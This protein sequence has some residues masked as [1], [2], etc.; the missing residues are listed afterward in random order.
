MPVAEAFECSGMAVRQSPTLFRSGELCA[1][2]FVEFKNI[3]Y[4]I[5]A[6][7]RQTV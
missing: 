5:S 4:L 2:V 1:F 3:D 7:I 6:N